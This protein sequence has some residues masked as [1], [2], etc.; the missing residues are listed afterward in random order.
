MFGL[1]TGGV[2]AL[3]YRL[4]KSMMLSGIQC[5]KRLYLEVHRP[6]LA[7]ADPE[8]ELRMLAGEQVGILARGSYPTGKLVESSDTACALQQTRLLV[9]MAQEIT[10]FEAALMHSDV[11]VRPDILVKTATGCRLVE[12]KSS[13]SIKEHHLWDCA[14]QSWVLEGAGCPL[15]AVA[16]VHVDSNFVYPGNDDYRG[17]LC[18]NDVTAEIAPYRDKIP[19]LVVSFQVLLKNDESQAAMGGHC[20]DPF[21]CPFQ[22][23]CS[24]AQ[25]PEYPVAI[26]PRGGRVVGELLADGIED[27]RNI[28]DGRLAR[29][30][31]ERVR[32]VTISGKAELAAEVG[33]TLRGLSYP[34]YYLDFET[35]QFAIPIWS[36]TRPYQQLPFQWSCHLESQAGKLSHTAF[37][38]CSGKAP[39]RPFAEKL[40]ASLGDQGPILVYSH[41][42]KAALNQLIG[43]FPD[44]AASLTGII[45]RLVDLLPLARRH[46]YHPQMKGSWSIKAVLP[47]VA[48]DLNYDDL[49]EI[50]DGLAAQQAYLEAIN[51]GT[52]GSRR[53]DLLRHL[54]EYCKLD[55][56]A[57]VRLAWFFQS[58]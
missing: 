44:L 45:D 14:I 7:E 51:P 54:D 10:L 11:L 30:I 32:R 4:S 28:P 19:D 27:V 39:M 26:L 40:I 5:P 29:E 37:L 21:P 31:H 3:N 8:G 17:L 20:G 50:H 24:P 46:Y 36:G 1:I 9:P 58:F 49:D 25:A 48:P 22:N 35:I 38:D 23:Y 15:E 42:E 16:L 43:M 33:V 34:R 52:N 6:E 53:Q 12:A 2:T 47:T 41:F 56:L 57:M 18:V 55:T 13:T